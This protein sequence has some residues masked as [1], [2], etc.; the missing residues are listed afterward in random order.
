M[1][2]PCSWVTVRGIPSPS[3]TK[4]GHSTQFPDTAHQIITHSLCSGSWTIT[5][6]LS[7]PRKLVVMRLMKPS[8]WMWLSS[9]NH[10]LSK[11]SGSSCTMAKNRAKY[12][13]LRCLSCSVNSCP[14]CIRYGN[15]PKSLN[16]HWSDVLLV[17]NFRDVVE[18]FGLVTA[19]F[20]WGHVHDFHLWTQLLACQTFPSVDTILY[21]YDEIL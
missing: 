5:S 8:K 18:D 16:N 13:I 3:S 19:T 6:G 9:E 21:P 2:W 20:D 4:Y 17:L 10:T 11:K 12:L 15:P 14:T 7:K 1:T